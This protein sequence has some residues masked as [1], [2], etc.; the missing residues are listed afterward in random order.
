L[1]M[2]SIF[3]TGIRALGAV[4]FVGCAL[5]LALRC[6]SEPA[7]TREAGPLNPNA[8]SPE[9]AGTGFPSMDFGRGDQCAP[10]VIGYPGASPIAGS[11]APNAAPLPAPTLAPPEPLQLPPAGEVLTVRLEAEL[12]H[13]AYPFR[14]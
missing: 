8:V 7:A 10:P 12:A 3:R 1:I 5:A 11:P 6:T 13:P 4:V 2:A 9:S 14:E